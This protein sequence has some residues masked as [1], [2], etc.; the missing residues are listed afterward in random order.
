MYDIETVV[1]AVVEAPLSTRG[2]SGS[3]VDAITRRAARPGVG[4]ARYLAETFSEPELHRTAEMANF[5]KEHATRLGELQDRP[6]L[7][8]PEIAREQC[9]EQGLLQPRIAGGTVDGQ[10]RPVTPAAEEWMR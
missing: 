7:R 9:L 3:V 2:R 5:A 8:R 10:E 1:K 6:R 4:G